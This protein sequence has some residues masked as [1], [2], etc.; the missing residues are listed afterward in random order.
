MLF[1]VDTFTELRVELGLSTTA[2][3]YYPQP[4]T[5]V[6]YTTR[7]ESSG[8]TKDDIQK[9]I[10]SRATFRPKFNEDI[11]LDFIHDVN[12]YILDPNDL[13]RRKEIFYLEGIE[14]GEKTEIRLFNTLNDIT[15][16]LVNDRAIIET[17]LE[18]RQF[19]PASFEA[20][21]DMTFT[22]LAAE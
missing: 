15:D 14:P 2:S 7:L 11:N 18:L 6:P 3:H 4:N 19:P 5:L 20:R 16:F 9:L 1:E 10:G 12:V 8:F 17:R 22:A 13:S 21:V